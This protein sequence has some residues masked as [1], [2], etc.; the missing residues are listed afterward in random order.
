MTYRFYQIFL[1]A[2]LRSCRQMMLYQ[3]L[4]FRPQDFFAPIFFEKSNIFLLSELTHVEEIF[5]LFKHFI[6][7]Q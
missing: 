7:D 3:M 2:L 6:I 1:Y 5:L 4:I